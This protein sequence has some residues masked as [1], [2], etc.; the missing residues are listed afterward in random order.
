M[1]KLPGDAA[2]TSQP[3]SSIATTPGASS[4]S[5]QVVT[6][7]ALTS[8]VSGP[9][10]PSS[11]TAMSTQ[12]AAIATVQAFQSA[13]GASAASTTG[14]PSAQPSSTIAQLMA[15]STANLTPVMTSAPAST[16]SGV[17]F[18]PTPIHSTN[19]AAMASP[20]IPQSTDSVGATMATHA[21]ALPRQLMTQA[22]AAGGMPAN[23]SMPAQFNMPGVHAGTF[24]AFSASIVRQYHCL[25]RTTTDQHR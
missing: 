5:G 25:T 8:S 1:A 4:V 16:Q 11:S 15:S 7:A 22:A 18:A 13:P 10:A 17:S 24:A 9:T 14:T 19:Q 21:G 2:S 12:A 6:A 3:A 20:M 23:S